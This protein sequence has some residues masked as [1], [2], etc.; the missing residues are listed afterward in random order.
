MICH[1]EMCCEPSGEWTA[2]VPSLPGLKAY[3][4]SREEA[5][6]K[7]NDLRAILAS[8]DHPHRPAPHRILAF[9]PWRRAVPA[10]RRRHL[11]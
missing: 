10:H 2:T 8:E 3:G 9:Y 5:L 7:A 11:E 4:S 6:E 1:I